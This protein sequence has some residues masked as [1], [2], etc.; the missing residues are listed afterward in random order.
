MSDSSRLENQRRVVRNGGATVI[1]GGVGSGGRLEH[2][3]RAADYSGRWVHLRKALLRDDDDRPKE[4]QLLRRIQCRLLELAVAAAVVGDVE[5]RRLE[6]G[7][8]VQAEVGVIRG[9]VGQR[10]IGIAF[11]REDRIGSGHAAI[12]E[13][14]GQW[15]LDEAGLGVNDV[16]IRDNLEGRHERAAS[17]A[18]TAHVIHAVRA[19]GLKVLVL[20]QRGEL[21]G[22]GNRGL[23]TKEFAVELV[24]VDIED[25]RVDRRARAG[26]IDLIGH[27]DPVVVSGES[28][29]RI[30]L[31]HESIARPTRLN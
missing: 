30:E 22:V 21:A 23:I 3:A 12:G 16:A 19:V 5:V 11:R 13:N 9:V 28:E 4:R 6:E 2:E 29:S 20:V 15:V 17:H 26:C 1:D 24:A 8:I 25:S 10:A 27:V 18:V 7:R 31:Q 14:A